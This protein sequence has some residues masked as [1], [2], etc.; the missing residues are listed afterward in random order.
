MEKVELYVFEWVV[1]Y[2]GSVSVEYGL[3]LMKFYVFYYSK[4]VE[5]VS[6]F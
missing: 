5:V 6:F 2:K 1:K 3:G 4:L